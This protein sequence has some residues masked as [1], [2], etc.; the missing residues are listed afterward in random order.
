MLCCQVWKTRHLF[1][2]VSSHW[3]RSCSELDAIDCVDFLLS[4][5]NKQ[6][7]MYIL[8]LYTYYIHTNMLTTITSTITVHFL[9]T[10]HSGST[11]ARFYVFC[12]FLRCPQRVISAKTW[13]LLEVIL[14]TSL[15]VKSW[16]DQMSA[17][18]LSGGQRFTCTDTFW[19]HCQR[20][21]NWICAGWLKA[22]VVIKYW[23]VLTGELSL[24]LDQ[25]GL[26][27]NTNWLERRSKL[28]ASDKNESLKWIFWFCWQQGITKPLDR[29]MR[30]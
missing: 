12:F 11:V 7:N 17:V 2:C 29:I 4:Y 13:S 23:T 14:Q 20:F 19:S 18:V 28:T 5:K 21:L 1:F 6:T 9:L 3:N 22:D 24:T 16:Q 15:Q 8:T 10:W 25:G 26:L 27:T 30:F